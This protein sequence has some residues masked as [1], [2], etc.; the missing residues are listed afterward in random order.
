MHQLFSSSYLQAGSCPTEGTKYL[1]ME[2]TP[3]LLWAE[4]PSTSAVKLEHLPQLPAFSPQ[5]PPSLKKS[6]EGTKIMPR[7]QEPLEASISCTVETQIS[8]VSL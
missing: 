8:T 7:H 4:M 2:Q 5:H 3:C 1:V 6:G